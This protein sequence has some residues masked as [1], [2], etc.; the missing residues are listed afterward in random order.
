V[1]YGPLLSQ[2]RDLDK[3]LRAVEEKVFNPDIQPEAS[4]QLRFHSRLHDRL[5]GLLRSVSAGYDQAPTPLLME[6]MN[7]LREQTQAYLQ[8]FNSVVST[9]VTAFNKN[10]LEHGASTLFTGT[11]LQL[12]KETQAGE[13]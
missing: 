8:Q 5:Q 11:P 6:E 2:S 1:N 12:N 9:D 10:A 4:D 3:K 13:D 7:S